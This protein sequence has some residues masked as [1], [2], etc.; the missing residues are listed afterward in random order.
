MFQKVYSDKLFISQLKHFVP[1]LQWLILFP[2][3]IMSCKIFPIFYIVYFFLFLWLF[4]F[5]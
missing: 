2:F 5:Y 4:E 3:N 1:S